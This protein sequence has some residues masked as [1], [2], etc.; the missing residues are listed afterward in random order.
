MKI[1]LRDGWVRYWFRGNLVLLPADLERRFRGVRRRLKIAVQRA[2]EE[3][4]RADEEKRR[5][6]EEKSRAEKEKRRADEA[7]QRVQDDQL[8][9][10]QL[11]EE[12]TRM[13]ALLAKPAAPPTT[14]EG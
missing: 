11:E 10:Q 9:F 3:K 5:A 4:R 8:R 1:A 12:L 6:D 2:D 13:R 14:N 7:V